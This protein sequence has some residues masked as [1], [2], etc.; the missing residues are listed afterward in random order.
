MQ[1][2]D[3]GVQRTSDTVARSE[4]LAAFAHSVA[5]VSAQNRKTQR[6]WA[7]IVERFQDFSFHV[8][9][10]ICHVGRVKLIETYWNCVSIITLKHEGDVCEYQITTQKT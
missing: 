8:D 5:K 6:S 1:V 10:K 9:V 2:V 7:T 4:R 3:S